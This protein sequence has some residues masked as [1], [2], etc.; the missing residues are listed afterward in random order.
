MHLTADKSTQKGFPATFVL[1]SATAIVARMRT[2]RG[3]LEGDSCHE[4]QDLDRQ[5]LITFFY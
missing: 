2:A 1:H 3:V 4:S 5:L